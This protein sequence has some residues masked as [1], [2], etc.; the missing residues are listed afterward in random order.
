M[1]LKGKEK[2]GIMQGGVEIVSGRNFTVGGW[3]EMDMQPCG[4]QGLGAYYTLFSSQGLELQ[5][6]QLRFIN[7]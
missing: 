1:G 7:Y 4:K 6:C 3:Q 2:L 5:R